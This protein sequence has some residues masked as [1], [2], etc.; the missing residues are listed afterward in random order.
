MYVI[1]L[2]GGIGTGKTTVSRMLGR[3][4]AH[5]V[6]ADLLARDVIEPGTPGYDDVAAEFPEAVGQDGQLDRTILARIV[7]A[8]RE[9]RMKLNSIVHPRVY[10]KIVDRL[11]D[12]A[13]QDLVVVLDIPL[14]VESASGSRG[15]VAEVVVV[16]ASEQTSLDRLEKRGMSRQDAAARM[17]A[18]APISDK[19][20]IA[21][22]VIRNEGSL[23][24]LEAQVDELWESLRAKAGAG[25]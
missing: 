15:L 7:F 16:S 24:E 14:L 18:Q 21:D 20:E 11:R 25:A 13:G 6:D 22:H 12:L 8:D 23:E 1:G 2:T 5:V 9:R 17:A 3:R 19:E 10:Q 4:G